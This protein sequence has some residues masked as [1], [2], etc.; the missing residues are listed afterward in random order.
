MNLTTPRQTA[1]WPTVTAQY[2]PANPESAKNTED[3][4]G[5]RARPLTPPALGLLGLLL[6]KYEPSA[7][8]PQNF[9]D[10]YDVLKKHGENLFGIRD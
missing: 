5:R 1:L 7:P 9:G 4:P 6:A 2:V 3:D 8:L 10:A